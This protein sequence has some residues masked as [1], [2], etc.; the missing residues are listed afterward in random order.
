M[1]NQSGT[2]SLSLVGVGVYF[3][4]L[5]LA[6]L[7]AGALQYIRNDLSSSQQAWLSSEV[8]QLD[9]ISS[10]RTPGIDEK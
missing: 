6:V 10:A 7:V 8:Y 3:V 4:T 5:S 1:V 9:T 2:I